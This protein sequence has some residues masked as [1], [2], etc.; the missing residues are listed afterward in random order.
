M[1]QIMDTANHAPFEEKKRQRQ[2][3][4]IHLVSFKFE[5]LTIEI[6][7]DNRFGCNFFQIEYCENRH[8]HVKY[9]GDE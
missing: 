3:R 5:L 2:M 6:L 1:P 8:E 7:T 9:A 4:F